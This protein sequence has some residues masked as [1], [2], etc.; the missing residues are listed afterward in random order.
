MATSTYSD[1]TTAIKKG[2][3]ILVRAKPGHQVRS[4]P[5][6]ADANQSRDYFIWERYRFLVDVTSWSSQDKQ[7]GVGSD[8]TSYSDTIGLQPGGTKGFVCSGDDLI[9]HQLGTDIYRQEQTWEHWGTWAAF[10][11]TDLA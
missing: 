3:W 5:D 1:T 6:D 9:A 10:D 11:E 7:V 8:L 2:E 4:D